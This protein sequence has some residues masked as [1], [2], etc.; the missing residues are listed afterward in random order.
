MTDREV[1]K[2][3]RFEL[4]KH[5]VLKKAEN[6]SV[7][8][9]LEL[10]TYTYMT[11]SLGLCLEIKVLIYFK[12]CFSYWKI[13]QLSHI[14]SCHISTLPKHISSTE[15]NRAVNRKINAHNP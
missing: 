1:S 9:C 10:S 4:T 7:H 11:I 12:T 3:E 2:L 14:F 6:T 15:H 13:L 8:P 5:S